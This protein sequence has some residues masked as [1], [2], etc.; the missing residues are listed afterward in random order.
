VIESA[1]IAKAIL[2]VNV[3]FLKKRIDRPK[4]GD[5][6][7]IGLLDVMQMD[8]D[9]ATQRLFCAVLAPFPLCRETVS[10]VFYRID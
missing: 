6:A 4:L 9:F 10:G 1:A 8:D 3:A 7:P 5:D 2:A